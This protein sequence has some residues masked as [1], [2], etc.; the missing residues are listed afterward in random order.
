MV[1]A[2]ANTRVTP[3]YAVII[4]QPTILIIAGYF[5]GRPNTENIL[6]HLVL[7]GRINKADGKTALSVPN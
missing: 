2:E 6:G 4:D 1:S 7:R 5:A 3:N